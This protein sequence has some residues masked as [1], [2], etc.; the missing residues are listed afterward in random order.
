MNTQKRFKVQEEA[1]DAEL[2]KEYRELSGDEDMLSITKR[3]GIS[4]AKRCKLYENQRNE[5]LGMVTWRSVE[6]KPEVKGNVIA[7]MRGVSQDEDSD[8]IIEWVGLRYFEPTS[9]QFGSPTNVIKW[10]PIPEETT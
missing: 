10:L 5:L 3:W 6:N 8:E 9:F 1:L 7:I 2:L 4:K